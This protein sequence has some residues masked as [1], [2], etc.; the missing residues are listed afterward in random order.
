MPKN[1]PTV[2]HIWSIYDY[3]F[4][5]KELAYELKK[6]FRCLGEEITKIYLTYYNFLIVQGL[7]QAHYE[8]LSIIFLKEFVN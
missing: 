7:W 1:I 3:H 2:F 5:I 6:Q 4:I 8:I